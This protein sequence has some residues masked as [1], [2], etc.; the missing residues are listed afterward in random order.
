MVVRVLRY[1]NLAGGRRRDCDPGQARPPSRLGK[2]STEYA[3][4]KQPRLDPARAHQSPRAR[5]I[6]LPAPAPAQPGGLVSL[7]RGGLRPGAPGEP[8]D[9]FEHRLL[10]LSLVPRDGTGVVRE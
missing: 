4:D 2:N 7:G 5:K 6:A 3:C 1:R 9:L 8:A 10:D